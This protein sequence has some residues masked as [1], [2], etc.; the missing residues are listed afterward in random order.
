MSD[1]NT[2]RDKLI[3]REYGRNTQNLITHAKTIEDK[4][5]RQA[6]VEEIVR[7][8]MSMHPVRNM[9]DYRLKVW[10]H[11]LQMADYELNV[12]IPDNIPSTKVRKVPDRMEY[13]AKHRRFRHYGHNVRTM[14]ERAKNMEDEDK[15]EA[16]IRVIAS[17]MKMAYKEWNRN[18]V[19]DEIIHKEFE[20]LAKG[21]VEI[22]D[23][24]NLN[25]LIKK[26][27]QKS[28][29]KGRSNSRKKSKYSNKSKKSRSKR[30][31]NKR[32][33][34]KKRRNNRNKR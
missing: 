8:I 7:L 28:R 15:K 21:D 2:Q 31:N 14:I 27:R 10:S 29:S 24:A 3:I 23:D 9:E 26:R 1:Y 11:V 32:G 30:N 25:K 18:N 34:S 20:E 19:N 4:D 13:P 17:Y 6:F 22:P 33:R 12:D 5:E 16:F